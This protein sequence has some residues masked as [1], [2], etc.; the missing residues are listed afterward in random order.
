MRP[1]WLKRIETATYVERSLRV[2]NAFYRR[3]EHA[4]T[5]EL[6]ENLRKVVPAASMNFR[7]LFFLIVANGSI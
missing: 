4:V 6:H 7:I 1:P 5:A 3:D 2:I